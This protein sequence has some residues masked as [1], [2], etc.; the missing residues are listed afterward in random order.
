MVTSCSCHCSST[1]VVKNCTVG[2]PIE[3]LS[4]N[5]STLKPHNP[6]K[7]FLQFFSLFE[8]LFT[9]LSHKPLSLPFYKYKRKPK[10][11]GLKNAVTRS[12]LRPKAAASKTWSCGF[13][14]EAAAFSYRV[15]MQIYFSMRDAASKTWSPSLGLH[16]AP[17]N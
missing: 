10:K 6:Y 12:K 9:Q 17:H 16:S 8:K 7:V 13:P 2:T 14:L 4:F 1:M 11:K 15:C 5:L 3:F